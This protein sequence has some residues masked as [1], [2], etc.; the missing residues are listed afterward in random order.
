VRTRYGLS[1][2]LE[3]ASRVPSY[4]RFHGNRTADVVIVGAGLTGCA[5]A[6]A[7]AAAGFDTLV[8]EAGR[9]GQGAT[10][11]SAGLWSPE[12][13]PS[14]RDLVAA[15]GLKDAR[16][17]FDAW[18]RGAL[19]GAAVLRRLRINCQL[20]PRETLVVARGDEERTLRRE[21]D[22]RRDA[23]LDV[24]WQTA[25]QVSANMKLD[26]VA[27]LKLREGSRSIRTRRVPASR[28]QLPGPGRPCP[29]SRR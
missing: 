10:S 23:G 19:E 4:P 1:P 6:Y 21:F 15:H 29:S 18:R 17:A 7:S 3:A 9:V 14:F 13:G 8:L 5:I 12:P 25:K 11:R 16:R 24:S 2:W 22:A 26:P 20:T 28:R 27:G